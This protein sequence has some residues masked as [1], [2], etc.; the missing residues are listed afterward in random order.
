LQTAQTKT[1]E[2]ERPITP[3]WTSLFGLDFSLQISEEIS[4]IVLPTNKEYWT[5]YK[6]VKP[7]VKPSIENIREGGEPP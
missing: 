1:V 3:S 2:T 7:H 6:D 5:I 4:G